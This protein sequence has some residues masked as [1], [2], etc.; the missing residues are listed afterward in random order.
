MDQAPSN[1][2]INFLASSGLTGYATFID[3]TPFN[4][5]R[6]NILD[7]VS[8]GY[9]SF[10]GSLSTLPDVVSGFYLVFTY[11]PGTSTITI[12]YAFFGE[13]CPLCGEPVETEYTRIVGFYTP[14]KTWSAKRKEE[15]KMREWEA[16]NETNKNN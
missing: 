15:Y 8:L 5:L 9:I 14:I 16:V 7:S 12:D 2:M 6:S 13:I 4:L 3:R 1:L 10:A 11:I